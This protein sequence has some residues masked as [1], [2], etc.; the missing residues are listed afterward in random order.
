MALKLVRA[1]V[2]KNWGNLKETKKTTLSLF[3]GRLFESTSLSGQLRW[4]TPLKFYIIAFMQVLVCN[5]VPYA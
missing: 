2:S 3:E 1:D 5:I 4:I